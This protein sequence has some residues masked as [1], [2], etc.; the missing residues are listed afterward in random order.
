MDEATE[1]EHIRKAVEI[2]TAITGSRPLGLYQ[3]KVSPQTRRLAVEEGGFLYDADSY[4]D[5]LPYWVTDSHPNMSPTENSSAVAGSAETTQSRPHLVVPYTLDANDFRFLMAQGFNCG[6]QFFTY[7]KD[8]FDQLWEEGA[9]APRMMSVGLHC[10]I[11]GRPG[12]AKA[13][14]RFLDYV[15]E[16][17]GVWVCRRVDIARHWHEHHLPPSRGSK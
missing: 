3:G 8:T 12:R 10:R 6:D 2:H 17:E 14:G 1:R 9:T 11:S 13:L 16:K 7:L 5:E 15:K 4:S